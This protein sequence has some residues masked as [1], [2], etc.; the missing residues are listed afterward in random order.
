MSDHARGAARASTRWI[1][2]TGQPIQCPMAPDLDLL[3][4][5]LPLVAGFPLYVLGGLRFRRWI[6]EDRAGIPRYSLHV[7]T[8]TLWLLYSG[9]VAIAIVLLKQ[10]MRRL[11]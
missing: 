11:G 6:V 4:R 5:W 9:A 10:A 7:E 1:R 3:N 2:H 8:I